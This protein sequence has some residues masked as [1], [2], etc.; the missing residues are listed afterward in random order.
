MLDEADQLFAIHEE[1][2]LVNADI[3]GSPSVSAQSSPEK[4]N[5]N[6]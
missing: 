3:L 2:M 1:E 5:L 4:I 6:E